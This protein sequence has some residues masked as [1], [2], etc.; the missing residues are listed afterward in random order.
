MSTWSKNNAAHTQT[1][2]T[3]KVL[4]QSG[5]VFS[6]SGSIKVKQF[7]FW[8]PT[9]SKRVRSVQARALA[10]QIDNVFRMVFLAE[11]ESGVTRTAAINAMKKI[12]SDGEKTMSDLGCKNDE[13]Y[14]FLGEPGDA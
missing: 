12:L 14:K 2:F 1:W 7:A 5:R 9:A 3:L 13:N 8:N 6:R 11:F 10:I 4:D